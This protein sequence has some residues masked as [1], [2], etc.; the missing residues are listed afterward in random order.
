MLVFL[1]WQLTGKCHPLFLSQRSRTFVFP[2]NLIGAPRKGERG[3]RLITLLGKLYSRRFFPDI[4]TSSS[5][6]QSLSP[7]FFNCSWGQQLFFS[8]R[9]SARNY[10]ESKCVCVKNVETVPFSLEWSMCVFACKNGRR[11]F[12]HTHSGSF[13]FSL[14]FLP[15]KRPLL[16]T[17]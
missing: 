13:P 2:K 10:W 4:C 11:I 6:Q 5:S 16:P 8:F 15:G 17:V 14:L 7:P 12:V 1:S 9:V 3:V